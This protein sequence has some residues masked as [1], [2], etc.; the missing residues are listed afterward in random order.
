MKDLIKEDG[1][2]LQ[3]IFNLVFIFDMMHVLCCN[4]AVH[5]DYYDKCMEKTLNCQCP[6]TYVHLRDPF[7]LSTHC[8]F[9]LNPV[10]MSNVPSQSVHSRSPMPFNQGM[11]INLS[12][13]SE[14]FIQCTE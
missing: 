4:K 3:D 13:Q 5:T 6:F 2:F 14:F 8:I 7:L 10:L 1:K 9:F 12:C 11:D